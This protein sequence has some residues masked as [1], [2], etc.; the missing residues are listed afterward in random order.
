M[1]DTGSIR[2]LRV[3]FEA[4]STETY[5]RARS[6]A[7]RRDKPKSRGNSGALLLANSIST[8]MRKDNQEKSPA[9]IQISLLYKR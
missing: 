1:I 3:F 8:T 2:I 7:Q 4:A 5:Y 9:S 6:K